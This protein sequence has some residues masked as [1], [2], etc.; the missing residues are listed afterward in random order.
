MRLYSTACAICALLIQFLAPAAAQE[1]RGAGD[2]VK[3]AERP[4]LWLIDGPQPAFIFGTIHIADKRVTTLPPVVEAALRVSDGVFTEIPLDGATQ[5]SVLPRLVR[6][7]GR[8]LDEV[9]PPDLYRRAE[10]YLDRFGLDIA[11]FNNMQTWNLFL[12]LGLAETLR[13]AAAGMP[14]DALL[15]GQAVMEGKET[16]GLETVDEQ[17]GIFE[18]L[19][20]E[21]VAHLLDRSLTQLEKYLERGQSPIRMLT[22]AYLSG[23]PARIQAVVEESFDT[24]DEKSRRFGE[25]I[26]VGRDRLMAERLVERMR[27]NPDKVYFFAVGAAHLTTPKTSVLALLEARGHRLRRLT[28]EDVERVTQLGEAFKKRAAAASRPAPDAAEKQ[29]AGAER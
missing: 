22:D 21:D 12:Q 13:E 24:S 5:M 4:L 2:R 11:M 16:G 23:D 7:D 25:E 14:L 29:P 3:P 27:K 18:R 1:A 8:S 9:L 17:L 6:T 20:E 28:P 19:S 26:I 10:K 15:F